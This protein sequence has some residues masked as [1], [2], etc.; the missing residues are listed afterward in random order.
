VTIFRA[1]AGSANA[2]NVANLRKRF[3]A[4]IVSAES[5][6]PAVL[7]PPENLPWQPG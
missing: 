3:D 2:T 7:P 5:K 6:W 4:C 1:V